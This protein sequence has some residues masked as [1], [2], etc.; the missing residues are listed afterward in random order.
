MKP[1]PSVTVSLKGGEWLIKESSPFETFIPEDISEEQKMILDMAHQFM[2]TYVLPN[3]ERADKMEPGFMRSL[4]EKTA[5]LGLSGTT[6]PEQYGGLGKDFLTNGIIMEGLGYGG[7][8]SVAYYVHTGIGTMPILYFGTEEQRQKYVTKLATCEWVGAYGLTEPGSGSD[9]LG[10]KTTA[11]LSADG[12]YYL[13]NGQKSWIS[14]GGFADVFTIFAKIDGDKFTAF[15]VERGFEGFTV[16][17]EEHKMGIKSSSTVPLFFQ[18]CKVPAEN[19]LGEIGKGH[20][21]AFNIL[22]NGRFKL[23]AATAGASKVNT[24]RAVQYAATREQFKTPIANFG[25]VKYK[26]GEMAIRTWVHESAIYRASKLIN[27]KEEE[28]LAAGQPFDKAFLSASEEYAIECAMLKVSGSETL[29]FIVD[30][31]LQIFGGNG[32]SD[33]YPISRAYRDSRINRIF[34]GTN[35]INRLLS[36]DMIL[37]RAMKGRL[38]VMSAAVAVSKEL[39][40]IPE[41]GNE[42]E[43]PFA[44]E[45]KYISNFKKA[46][47]LAAGAA[48]Q[49]YMTALDK[50]QEILMNVADMFINT[51]LAESALLRLM[52]LTETYSEAST[53]LKSDIVCVYIYDAA[54]RILKAGKEAI[55]RFAEGD[56]LNIMQMGLRRFTKVAPYDTISA[57]RNIA[58]KMI[59]ENGYCF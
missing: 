44:K 52:K 34:E 6:V 43:T 18:D 59:E 49:K 58:E 5:E 25:A 16:G 9:A 53:K 36:V 10:A 30:E 11:T 1:T 2:N 39:M 40:S 54:E 48:V 28:L 12:K 46:I 19:V 38:D 14:N 41:F 56:E 21:I 31:A 33:E 22:N 57:R 29:D 3:L 20:L 26:L 8:F 45:K 32:F 13:L 37:K 4:L 7:G 55:N 24:T 42:D 17:A 50:E 51:Y 47:L 35:E 23:G 15:I 27:D